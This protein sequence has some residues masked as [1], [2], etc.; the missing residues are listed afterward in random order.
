[1]SKKY[2][3]G[4][5]LIRIS[6]INV[7]KWHNC[8]YFRKITTCF[9]FLKQ[10]FLN[11]ELIFENICSHTFMLLCHLCAYQYLSQQFH[12]HCALLIKQRLK[13]QLNYYSEFIYKNICGAIKSS[14]L[15]LSE[16]HSKTIHC[17]N[18]LFEIFI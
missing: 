3:C 4:R 1:M 6:E 10:L 11:Y 7:K 18:L 17:E 2:D 13:I 12:K 9:L 16:I 8:V 15:Y 14:F 5:K